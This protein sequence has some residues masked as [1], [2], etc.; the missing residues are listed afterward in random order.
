MK[1]TTTK[2]QTFAIILLKFGCRGK[3]LKQLI[4]KLTKDA[5]VAA[6]CRDTTCPQT[7]LLAMSM[8]GCTMATA[9]PA[10]PVCS[11]P[12]SYPCTTQVSSPVITSTASCPGLCPSTCAPACNPVCCRSK[13]TP[14]KDQVTKQ[15]GAP[16]YD[17]ALE[18]G[19]DS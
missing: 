16:L 7:P 5:I 4:S 6:V 9:C 1:T 11:P 19:E 17:Y 10:A 12:I 2:N 3:H 13:I 14:V 18:D 8:P 15:K